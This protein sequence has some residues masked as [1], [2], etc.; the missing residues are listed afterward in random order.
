MEYHQFVYGSDNYGVLLH[1]AKSGATAAIDAGDADSYLEALKEKEWKLSQIWITHH[2]GDHVAGLKTLADETGATVYGP[3]QISGVT[4]ILNEGDTIAFASE[5]VGVIATP[6]HTL[7]ML[8]YYVP[9]AGY[10]FAGDS[11]FSLGCGR[12]FEGDGP[13][14]WESLKKLRSLPLSTMVFCGHEYTASNAKFLKTILPTDEILVKHCDNKIQLA[15]QGIATVPTAL[16]EELEFNLFLRAD[17]PIVA[18]AL[19]ISGLPPDMVFSKI[20]K[21]KDTF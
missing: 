8:N 10:L 21:S 12:L 17:D 19:G 13:M 9:G 16:K 14:M 11:L 4:E 7:D 20:R 15:E 1:D 3:S 18:D 6:G 2:H 5:T